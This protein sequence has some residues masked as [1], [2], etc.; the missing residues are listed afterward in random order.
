MRTLKDAKERYDRMEI[1]Q[2]L[3]GRVLQEVGRAGRRRRKLLFF[4]SLKQARPTA[5]LFFVSLKSTGPAPTLKSK[6]FTTFSF[7]FCKVLFKNTPLYQLGQR[8]RILNAFTVLLLYSL[9]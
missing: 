5:C 1:P 9:Y 7:A 4:H 6:S 3:S 2:E 8:I